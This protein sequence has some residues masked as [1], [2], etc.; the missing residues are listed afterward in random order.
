MRL[1]IIRH[2]EP[3]YEHNTITTK[4]HRE[5]RALGKRLKKEGLTR[6]YSSPLGRALHTAEYTSK[7]TG[8]PVK[9][10]PW[11]RE[12]SEL[13]IESVPPWGTLMTWDLPGEIIREKRKL[14]TYDDW[15]MI[16][17][18]GDKKF[19]SEVNRVHRDSDAFLN[20]HGYQRVGGKYRILKS[21]REKLAVFCH[22]GL[23]IT[24]LAHL[25]EIP[26]PL[27]WSGFWMAP[28]SVTTI[29]FD[30]RSKKWAVPRCIGFC[31]TSHLR[32]EGLPVSTHGIK[33]NFD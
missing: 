28:S 19:K 18:F 33:A 14:L 32:M 6:I 5:A 26:L 30:E 13:K 1:Y 11:S 8:L 27:I 4:G 3:D 9:V 10:E 20:R 25:L 17:H 15:H 23:G 12:L 16:P 31:D 7:T 22:G 29:L 21:N 24:W 2:A